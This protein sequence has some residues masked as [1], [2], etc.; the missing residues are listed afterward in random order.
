ML[1]ILGRESGRGVCCVG[2]MAVGLARTCAP[3]GFTR[4]A[5][6][7]HARVVLFLQLTVL[8]VRARAQF[9]ETYAIVPATSKSSVASGLGK[10]APWI[11]L[12]QQL[13]R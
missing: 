3:V 12:A 9:V 8:R 5:L 7:A 6:C 4:C 1:W 2:L 13:G 11:P 10:H